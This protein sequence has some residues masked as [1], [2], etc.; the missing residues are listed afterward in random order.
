MINFLIKYIDKLA[1][2]PDSLLGA[3]D[4]EENAIIDE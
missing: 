4:D 2:I 1:S 3:L